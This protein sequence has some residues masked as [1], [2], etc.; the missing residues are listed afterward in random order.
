[1][2]VSLSTDQFEPEILTETVQG[3]FAGKT[4]MGRLAALGIAIVEGTMPHSGPKAIGKKVTVPRFGT[5]G[6]FVANGEGTP[7]VP[8]KLGMVSEESSIS[9]DSLSFEVSAW[10]QGNGDLFP[11]GSGDPYE[12]AARQIQE[13]AIRAMDK[14]LIDAGGASGVY[15]KDVHSLSTPVTISYDLVV[16]AKFD[17]WGDEQDDIAAL[18]V[19]S[20]THKDLLKLKDSTGRPLLLDGQGD[21]DFDRF[22]GKPVIVSDRLP[23]TGS[24]MGAV[25][26]SGTTPPVMTITGT[27]LGP[28]RLHVD[29]TLSH[30]SDSTIRFSTDGGNTWSEE[31]AVADDSVPVALIDTN[32][33]SLVGVNGKTGL[34]VAFASGTFNADNLWISTARVKATSLLL[35]KSAMAFWYNR[36]ALRLKTDENILQDTDLGAMHLYGVAH[37]YGRR[38]GGSRSGVVQLVHN[39]SGF[40]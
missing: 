36:Q 8:S 12:E 6:E 13:A 9:R 18:A 40:L 14:R 32:A 20:Q 17:G 23:F 35:K 29:C 22:C 10:A 21:G 34:S 15:V 1:M 27:P 16:D 39:V 3:V 24:T 28:W 31:I 2:T 19:H 4:I 33:D 30:A 26:S 25:T 5:L 38:P 37:R 7:S 11:G